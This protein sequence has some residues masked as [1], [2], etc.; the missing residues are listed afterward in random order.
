VPGGP[1]GEALLGHLQGSVPADWTVLVLADR[2][3]YARWLCT[4]IQALGW[5]PFLLRID[6][7]NRKLLTHQ[8]EKVSRR[9]ENFPRQL[10]SLSLLW[11]GLCTGCSPAPLCLAV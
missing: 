8:W 11:T 9:Q 2:G 6:T 4:T 3:L 1:H 7:L 5:H 10:F